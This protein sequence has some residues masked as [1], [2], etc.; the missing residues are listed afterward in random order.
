MARIGIFGGTFNPPHIGHLIAAEHVHGQLD[1]TKVLFVPAALPPH[2]R[3]EGV[4]EARHRLD[5]LELA[6]QMNRHF[7]VSGVEVTRGGVSYTIDTLRQI[8]ALH[9]ADSL[10]FVMG[11][12]MLADFSTWKSPGEIL[13]LAELVVLTRP[14]YE[15]PHLEST[16][17]R[18]IQVCRIPEVGISSSD[19][20]RRVKEGKS[21][22]YM[23][24]TAV[25][26]YIRKHRLYE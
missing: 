7:Q 1:L 5:M 9:P 4:T 10:F 11:M 2:K 19:I 25:E 22:R 24:P 26:Q 15:M 8:S 3:D 17:K 23:V 14:G 20:R 18:R 6:V 13:E 16:V 12:D 21:I